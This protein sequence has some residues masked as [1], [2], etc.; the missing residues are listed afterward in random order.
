MAGSI[1]RGLQIL[2]DMTIEA[3]SSETKGQVEPQGSCTGLP[4][5]DFRKEGAVVL[6]AWNFLIG[7]A[8]G[9]QMRRYPMRWLRHV[10]G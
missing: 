4:M 8:R 6:R 2:L 10:S 1:L 3:S 7:W 5:G 9:L